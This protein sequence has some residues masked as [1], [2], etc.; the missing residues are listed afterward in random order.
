MLVSEVGRQGLFGGLQV[1]E[2]AQQTHFAHE[3]VQ[4]K[5]L[6]GLAQLD[7][8]DDMN[9]LSCCL[10]NVNYAQLIKAITGKI[11]TSSYSAKLMGT[12]VDN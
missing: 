6:V 10:N 12:A 11:I 3:A 1:A 8:E 7:A 2:W 9:F 4:L 5:L